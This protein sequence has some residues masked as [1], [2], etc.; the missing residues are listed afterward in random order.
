MR[1][2]YGAFMYGTRILRRGGLDVY[3]RRMVLAR[4]ST[5]T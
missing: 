3:M 2:L 1:I 5:A 4:D